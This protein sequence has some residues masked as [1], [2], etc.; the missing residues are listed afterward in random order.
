VPVVTPTGTLAG[1]VTLD[2]LL[3]TVAEQLNDIV[4][5]ITSEQAREARA[6]RSS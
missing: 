3:E 4:R 2:D 5:A 1:I 6:R